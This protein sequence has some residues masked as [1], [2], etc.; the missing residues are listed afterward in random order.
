MVEQEHLLAL[1]L[2][3]NQEVV[4]AVQVELVVMELLQQE[5]GLAALVL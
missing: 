1:V 5:A 3:E 2:M 4:E